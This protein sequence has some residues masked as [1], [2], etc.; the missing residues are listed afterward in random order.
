ML[1]KWSLVL[2][3]GLGVLVGACSAQTS[4]D[5][6]G[7]DSDET[8]PATSQEDL[9]IG[10]RWQRE[11]GPC[12]ETLLPGDLCVPAYWGNAHWQRVCPSRACPAGEVW[13][14]SGCIPRF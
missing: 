12:P 6:Q 2:A 8:P 1:T 11:P 3:A 4:G 13:N 14:G 9:S 5:G 10:C 7:D